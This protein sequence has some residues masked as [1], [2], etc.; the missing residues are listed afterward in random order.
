[1]HW[2]LAIGVHGA[3]LTQ[4]GTFTS[5][6]E[7]RKAASVVMKLVDGNKHPEV[8]CIQDSDPDATSV[9]KPKE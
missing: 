3:L 1:M 7:C 2:I 4:L 6:N 5:Y 9:V 8:A